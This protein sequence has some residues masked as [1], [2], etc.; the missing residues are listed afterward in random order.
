MFVL[1]VAPEINEIRVVL[2]EVPAHHSRE[3]ETE[4]ETERETEKMMEHGDFDS[5]RDEHKLALVA[6]KTRR[7]Y[8][9]S[10]K[11]REARRTTTTLPPKEKSPKMMATISAILLMPR[12]Q[13]FISHSTHTH[14]Q[15]NNVIGRLFRGEEL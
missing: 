15:D 5:P 7:L 2:I 13:G 8:L 6:K 11:K 12:L 1:V 9:N 3:T 4:R 14:T 10:A